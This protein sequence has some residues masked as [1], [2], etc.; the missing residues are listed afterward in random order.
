MPLLP[1]RFLARGLAGSRQRERKY[2]LW[3]LVAAKMA[4]KGYQAWHCRDT[5]R[6]LKACISAVDQ[7]LMGE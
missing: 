3:R 4:S 1:G 6:D 7:R 2:R 5:F